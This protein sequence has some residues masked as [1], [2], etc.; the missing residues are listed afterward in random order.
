[1]RQIVVIQRVHNRIHLTG[2]SRSQ[3]QIYE[4]FM[5][6]M[7]FRN[8]KIVSMLMNGSERASERTLKRYVWHVTISPHIKQ[9][10][11]N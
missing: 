4:Y 1:M 5:P 11:K 9:I 6:K 10:E 7:P 8:A 2:V 3:L